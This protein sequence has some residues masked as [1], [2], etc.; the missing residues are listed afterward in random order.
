MIGETL[1]FFSSNSSFDIPPFIRERM[2][3]YGTL[4]R[5][6][7][8]GQCVVVSTDPEINQFIFQQE[9]RLFKSWYMDS[10]T[11]LFGSQ[12]VPSAHSF[13]HKY[14]RSLILNLFGPENLKKNLLPE[15]EET[16][17]RYLQLWSSMNSVELKDGISTM[18]FDLIAKKMLS[19]DEAKSSAKLRENFV[20]FIKGLISFPLNIPGTA[21]YK[22]LQVQCQ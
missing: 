21:Y 4:F 18:I 16:S 7:L 11:E 12:T 20:D 3:R 15:V 10:F 2:K 22:C 9:G 8:V 19:Y 5:T 17:R 13:V 14:F 1:Q 6:S